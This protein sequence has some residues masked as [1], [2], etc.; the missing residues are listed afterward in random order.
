MD[1]SVVGLIPSA[2]LVY[3]GK[4]RDTY[5]L[6]NRRL[7][8]V[9]SDRVSAFDVVLPATIPG[10]GEI[11]T[12]LSLFW[13]EQTESLIPNHLTGES[14]A[15][16]GWPNELTNA[17]E[18]R[19]IVVHQAERI[20]VECVVRGYLAGSGWAEYNRTGSVAGHTLPANLQVGS[21][22]PAPIFT[23]ARKNDAG[24]DENITRADLENDIGSEIAT[25]LETVS[26]SLYQRAAESAV[27]RGVIIADTKFE[28]GFIDGHLTL[29]DEVLTPDSSRFWDRSTW[30]PGREPDSWD[31]Q[32]LRNWLVESGWDRELPAPALP[33]EVI[34]GTRSRY[35]EAFQRLTGLTLH[36]W[37]SR[38]RVEARA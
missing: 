24:H 25:R 19:S 6:S 31:K 16:L 5:E 27:A 2:P 22:L 8:M 35:L 10:K 32:Y 26:L 36:E 34:Q 9:A 20:P 12:Q 1:A 37:L 30:Q 14:V 4:V 29:I 21:R 17:L 38:D 11:L 23:P 7:L 13:F 28:F 15:D 33:D 3:S 18:R